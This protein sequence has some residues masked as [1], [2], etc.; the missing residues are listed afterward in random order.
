MAT[1][2]FRIY[3]ITLLSLSL[4]LTVAIPC[5]LF[6]PYA[7]KDYLYRVYYLR[8]T[9]KQPI[10]VTCS[11][12]FHSRFFLLFSYEVVEEAAAA[13]SADTHVSECAK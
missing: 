12:C 9:L 2:S 5:L 13:A 1:I 3:I 11:F 8:T 6:N 10:F 4:H 7:L